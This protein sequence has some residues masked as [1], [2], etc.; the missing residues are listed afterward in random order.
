MTSIDDVHLRLKSHRKLL[1]SN[2]CYPGVLFYLT[3]GQ[4]SGVNVCHAFSVVRRT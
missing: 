3:A 4:L 1:S 2:E